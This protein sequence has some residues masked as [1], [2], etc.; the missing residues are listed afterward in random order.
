MDAGILERIKT[1]PEAYNK[2]ES[3]HYHNKVSIIR[4][5]QRVLLTYCRLILS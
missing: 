1:I 4:N 3:I 5:K 2:K